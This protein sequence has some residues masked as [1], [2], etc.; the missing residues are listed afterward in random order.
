MSDNEIIVQNHTRVE[1]NL[2]I[3]EVEFEK[4]P[5]AKHVS[6]DSKKVLGNKEQRALNESE[7]PRASTNVDPI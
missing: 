1:R 2:H 4:M 6:G 5:P 7:S 3:H